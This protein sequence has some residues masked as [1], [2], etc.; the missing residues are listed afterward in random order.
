M[1]AR[2]API[3]GGFALMALTAGQA[4]AVTEGELVVTLD[5]DETSI[6]LSACAGFA[7]STFT[8]DGA[9]SASSDDSFE[10]RLTANTEAD[11]ACTRSSSTCERDSE[12]KCLEI[13][14]SHSFSSD[15][16]PRILLGDDVCAAGTD[17]K[18]YFFLQYF[19]EADDAGTDTDEEEHSAS[20]SLRIDLIAPDAP[21]SPP[22]SVAN[23]EEALVVRISSTDYFA[24]GIEVE[25][26]RICAVPVSNGVADTSSPE[27]TGT[28]KTFDVGEDASST[29]E[30]RLTGLVNGI[31]YSVVY[32]EVD[33]AGNMGPF[34][35][36]VL[37]TP[38]EVKDFAEYYEE[39]CISSLYT[40]TS[41]GS[42]DQ[43]S[44]TQTCNQGACQENTCS[45]DADC[46]SGRTCN[47]QT[48]SCAFS[49]QT[50]ADKCE[51]G[52][53]C[54]STDLPSS[55]PLIG[56]GLLGLAVLRRRSV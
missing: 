34:S 13:S 51:G 11:T 9:Y 54:E 36:G 33:Q 17:T 3:L 27:L 25:D 15:F 29:S 5:P 45:T 23:S 14:T 55:L 35:A 20:V 48:R 46:L 19:K 44:G 22:D 30:F 42:D 40:A 53:G 16:T 39:I 32:A 18:V 38:T 43:C 6:G 24:T 26:L 28:C 49:S 1:A 56:F 41:C 47:T 50:L 10:L 8:V 12:C 21:S 52:G 31:E 37:G 2:L 7:D 4:A